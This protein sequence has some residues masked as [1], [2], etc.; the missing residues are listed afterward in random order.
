MSERIQAILAER[1]GP[2]G[3]PSIESRESIQHNAWAEFHDPHATPEE[4]ELARVDFDFQTQ[5]I[6]RLIGKEVVS[7]DAFMPGSETI[8]AAPVA[9]A[10]HPV[11]Q[12]RRNI[13]K[14]MTSRIRVETGPTSS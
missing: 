1:F 7:I 13:G 11:R 6:H 4:R 10:S 8:E 12:Q 3:L 2:N 9:E 14:F 5:E